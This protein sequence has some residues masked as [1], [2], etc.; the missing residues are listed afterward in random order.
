M[1]KFK[2]LLKSKINIS[3]QQELFKWGGIDFKIFYVK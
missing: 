1:L 2:T 3:S